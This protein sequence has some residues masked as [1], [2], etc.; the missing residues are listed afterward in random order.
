MGPPTEPRTLEWQEIGK[1]RGR[2]ASLLETCPPTADSLTLS[3]VRRP[4][5]AEAPVGQEGHW[6]QMAPPH[7]TH[8]G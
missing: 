4:A 5:L 6:Y 8:D 7:R 3:T 2:R 1:V